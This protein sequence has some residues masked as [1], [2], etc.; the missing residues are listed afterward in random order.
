MSERSENLIRFL[1]ED[2]LSEEQAQDLLSECQN[3]AEALSEAAQLHL[4]IVF[5]RLMDLPKNSSML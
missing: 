5:S 1:A 3:D 2:C 4:V